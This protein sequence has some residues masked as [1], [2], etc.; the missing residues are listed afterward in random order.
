MV[1]ATAA[2]TIGVIIASILQK[3]NLAGAAGK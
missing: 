3:R 1:L 2:T